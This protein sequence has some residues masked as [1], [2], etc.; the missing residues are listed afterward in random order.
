MNSPY[1]NLSKN[2]QDFLDQVKKQC[3]N[4]NVILHLENSQGIEFKNT[5][6][7]C[8]GYFV[9]SPHPKLGVATNKDIK[10]WFLV[11]LH[12]YCHMEQWLEKSP[13]WTNNKMEKGEAS[14]LIDS[15]M[16]NE[17]EIASKQL[18]ELFNIVIL[19]EA[20]CEARA[21]QNINNFQLD[22]RQKDLY[23]LFKRSGCGRL[24]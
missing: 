23:E 15:W 5:G 14:D 9:D 11:L 12:E 22:I 18:E 21:I 16:N 24:Y 17:I 4:Y 7:M 2:Q 3:D 6:I 8:N 13:Y 20:D 1:N 10:D 19:L